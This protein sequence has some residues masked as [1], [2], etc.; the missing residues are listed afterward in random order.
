M[1]SI[2]QQ[3]EKIASQNR[4][5]LMT[6]VV[7]GYPTLEATEK[8]VRVMAESKVDFIEM[9]IPFSDPLADGPTIMRA[10]E[11]SLESGTKVHDA[12]EM[13]KKISREIDIPLLFMAYY[14]TIFNMVFQS[15]AAMLKRR[16][17]P[18]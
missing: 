3:L 16:E 18:D 1:N 14:N 7:I 6:H 4:L 15:F 11:Q 8:L 10:C 13:A 5:G 17:F 12:F 2:T 9:Q